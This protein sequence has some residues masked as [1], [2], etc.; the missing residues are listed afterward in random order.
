MLLAAD[1]G[2]STPANLPVERG[3]TSS[4]GYMGGAEDHNTQIGDYKEGGNGSL[5]GESDGDESDDFRSYGKG[6]GGIVDI[7]DT[8]KPGCETASPR[9]L[10]CAISLVFDVRL[11]R[12]V[13]FD[14]NGRNLRL[15]GT[16]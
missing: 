11:S 4:L 9:V 7:W 3:F 2:S 16:S 6:G 14:R 5:S 8:D 12:P 1:A 13:P 10:S 15:A